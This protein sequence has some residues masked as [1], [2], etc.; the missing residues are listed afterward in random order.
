[1]GWQARSRQRGGVTVVTPSLPDRTDMLVEAVASLEAQTVAPYDHLVQVD[2]EFRGPGPTMNDL[3]ARVETEWVSILPDDDLFDPDYLETMLS[4]TGRGAVV[5]SWCRMEG[6]DHQP[7]RGEWDPRR[8]LAKQD[9]GFCGVFLFKKSLWQRLGGF[10][11]ILEDWDFL[12]R[13]IDA[14][15]R[16]APVYQ[17][18]WTYRTHDRNTSHVIAAL[19]DGVVPDGPLYHLG[20]HMEKVPS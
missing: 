1:M 15:T 10:A 9:S 7:Y 14:G 12:C 17:E 18:N 2:D 11:A 8:L 16:F 5:M 19:A 3:V 6:S 13:A 20:R 4:H